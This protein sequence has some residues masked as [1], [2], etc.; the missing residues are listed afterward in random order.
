MRVSSPPITHP[1]F[2]GIDTPT[3]EEL[4]GSSHSV[5]ETRKY[6]TADSL[7]YLSLDGLLSTVH[8]DQN[9]YCRACFTGDYPVEF[10]LTERPQVELFEEAP[11]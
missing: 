7:E 8:P 6:I 1:C 4:I 5:E 9:S 2:Y 11:S 3:R 10:P